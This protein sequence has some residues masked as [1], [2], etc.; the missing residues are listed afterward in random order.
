MERWRLLAITD[1]GWG[2]RAN[3]ESQGGLI[4]CLCDQDVID[5]KPGKTW[6]IKTLSAQNGLDAIEFAQSFLQK[7]LYGMTPKDFQQWVPDKASGL[8][9]DS[10]SLYDA[11]T[12]SAC[13]SAL[14]MEKRLAIDY[15]IARACLSERHVQP[16]WTNN[17]QMIA[18]CLTKLK[19]N[20]EILFRMLDS[21]CYHVR[22]SKESGRKEAARTGAARPSQNGH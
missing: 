10:K 22:P 9:I 13:S 18:D 2:V 19:G 4:L 14:A 6:V 8:V 20:K 7:V 12:R 21:C 5:R 1:A 15:A 11:L 16:C 3:G 17:L